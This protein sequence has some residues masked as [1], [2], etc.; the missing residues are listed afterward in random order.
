LKYLSLSDEQK[1]LALFLGG[2]LIAKVLS[3]VLFF[4]I[5]RFLTPEEV[6]EI[7]IYNTTTSLLLPILS[8]Q[9]G[10]ANIRFLSG[11]Y[12]Q[13]RPYLTNI[14]TII[15]CQIFFIIGLAIFVPQKLVMLT[16]IVMIINN[17][18]ALYARAINKNQYF[19]LIEIVQR[20]SMIAML[21][22]IF[23]YHTKGY[24]WITVISYL[25][26]DIVIAICLRKTFK[27]VR[28][29]F[30]KD[31]IKEVISYSAPLILNSLGWWLITSADRYFI[32]YFYSESFVGTYSVVTKISSAVMLIM[33]NIYYV[34]Q[35]R[36]ISY[37]DQGIKIPHHLNKTYLNVTFWLTGIGLLCPKELLL[38]LFGKQYSQSLGLYY[39][40]VPTIMYWSLSVLYGIGYLLKKKT[41][42]AST[43]T[44]FC[45]T[46][47]VGLNSFLINKYAIS[48]AIYS[49]TISLFLWFLIRYISQRDTLNC[50]MTIKNG[51]I[52]LIL[53]MLSIWRYINY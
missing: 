43:T 4:I 20:I 52:I 40:F 37:Y 7:E 45:A 8:L 46:I 9:V 49:T 12:E 6:G 10:E 48:G 32:R 38:L 5:I 16:V 28:S 31:I 33:Q 41:K 34:F 29:T 18:L 22:G 35:K 11:N 23:L 13:N 15:I 24:M 1:E 27:F 25:I 50:R 51:F 30:R 36:Y 44:L 19:R 21:Y 3:F 42:E 47:N 39:L 2:S 26:S 17:F 14:I 53:Q